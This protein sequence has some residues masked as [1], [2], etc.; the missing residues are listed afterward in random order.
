[1]LDSGT[2]LGWCQRGQLTYVSLHEFYLLFQDTLRLAEPMSGQSTSLRYIHLAIDVGLPS[3]LGAWRTLALCCVVSI[4]LSCMFNRCWGLQL[5]VKLAM[6]PFKW[7]LLW[8]V[9]LCFGSQYAGALPLHE[10]G[11]VGGGMPY[12]C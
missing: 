8:W 5:H 12:M 7:H 4:R 1:M 10:A 2:S 3:A 6:P 11:L 9:D